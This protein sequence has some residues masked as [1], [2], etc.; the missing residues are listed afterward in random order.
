MKKLTIGMTTYDDFDGVYFTVQSLRLHHPE[1]MDQVEFIVV[2]NNPEGKH[3]REVSNLINWNS[4]IMRYVPF[5]DYKSTTVKTKVFELA[6]TEYV[7]CLD[8]HVLVGPGA[9][10]KLLDFFQQGKDSGNLLQ[11]PMLYDDLIN[12]STHFELI[13]R[14]QMWGIWATDERGKNPENEPF[15]IPAQGM[16][17]FACRKDSWLGYNPRFRGFGG[18]EGYIHEKF[19]KAGKKTLCLPFLRWVHRFGRPEGI[20]YPLAL[21]HKIRNYLIGFTELGMDLTPIY[22]HFKEYVS[23]EKIDNIYSSVKNPLPN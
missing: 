12:I 23:I 5:S 7:M 1:V 2:D 3:S 10:K 8:G 16:G 13:W 21:E 4:K 19:R 9:I 17:L 18:E 20:K 15:E 6:N 14:G 11:G 22:E